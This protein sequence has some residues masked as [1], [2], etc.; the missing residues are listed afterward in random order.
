M[1]NPLPAPLVPGLPPTALA[2]MQDITFAPFMKLVAECGAPDYLFTAFYRVHEH[3]RLD[4]SIR[5]CIEGNESGRP[6]FAQLIGEDPDHLA[7]AVGELKGLPIAGIDLNLGCPAPKVYKKN[8]GGGLLRDPVRIGEIL[9]RLRAEIPGLFSVKMR[10]GFEDDR[11]FEII[12]DL[13]EANSVDLVSLHARTVRQLY[14]GRPDYTYIKRAVER[15]PC[16]VLANGDITS[17]DKAAEVLALTGAHGVMIGRTAVRNP[18]IFRQCREKFSGTNVFA[19]TFG[20]VRHYVDR[21]WEATGEPGLADKHHIPRMKKL[22]NFIGL[23]VDPEGAFLRNMRTAQTA[24]ELFAVC[25][26]FLT[27]KGR[28]SVPFATEPHANLLARPNHEG[29]EG[30][31]G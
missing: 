11:H 17:A 6:I 16:P 13:L 22:L 21:L 12:L 8:V 30:C 10:F 19:P 3:S 14:R 26:A 23:G 9:A 18:W 20:D 31:A 5:E 4:D 7:R 24:A 2:P 27:A 25:D 29:P 15:L 28:S 1:K